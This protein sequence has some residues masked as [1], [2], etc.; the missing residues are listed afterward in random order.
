MYVLVAMIVWTS[1]QVTSFTQEFTSI[2]AC[3][4]AKA[5]VDGWNLPYGS[6]TS[7]VAK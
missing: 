6:R 7:C 1:G 2:N 5:T 3:S 4:A